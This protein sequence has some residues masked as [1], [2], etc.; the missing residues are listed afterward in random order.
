V[1]A[2]VGVTQEESL[3]NASASSIAVT[4]LVKLFSAVFPV[5]GIRF[6]RDF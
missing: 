5:T 2:D 1:I 4:I 6:G 3:M